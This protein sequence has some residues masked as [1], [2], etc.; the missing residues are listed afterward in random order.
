VWA[1]H[2]QQTR[3]STTEGQRRHAEQQREAAGQAWRGAE[4]G[5]QTEETDCSL[6]KR[7]A[8][9]VKNCAPPESSSARPMEQQYQTA[10]QLRRTQE[11]EMPRYE[12]RMRQAEAP[13]QPMRQACQQLCH[14]HWQ[15]IHETVAAAPHLLQSV[16]ER[17]GMVQDDLLQSHREG[18]SAGPHGPQAFS[19]RSRSR[20]WQSRNVLRVMRKAWS[21]DSP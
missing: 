7:G 16:Q 2:E 10:A 11:E 14:K 19:L 18:G 1:L 17:L 15:S 5:R 13:R 3:T 20:P 9:P 12:D 6:W 8:V 21:I 4:L